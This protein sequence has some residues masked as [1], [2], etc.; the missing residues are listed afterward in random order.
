MTIQNTD[1]TRG[2]WESKIQTLVGDPT[3][4]QDNPSLSDFSLSI[5]NPLVPS[6]WSEGSAMNAPANATGLAA[7][8]AEFVVVVV[9]R[10][11]YL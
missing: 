9:F 5:L 6:D 4:L 11:R 2:P 1:L 8:I 3:G 10:I 7:A